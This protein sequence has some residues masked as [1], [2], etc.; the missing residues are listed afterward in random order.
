M[1]WCCRF[2]FR[3]LCDVWCFCLA[4]WVLVLGYA[5][6]LLFYVGVVWMFSLMVLLGLLELTLCGGCWVCLLVA[7]VG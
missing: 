5:S 6:G 2:D 3:C 4:C 1:N 7:G